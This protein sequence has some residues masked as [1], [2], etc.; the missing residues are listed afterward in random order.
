M[1]DDNNSGAVFWALDNMN[2]RQA[3]NSPNHSHT[4]I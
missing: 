2:E 4:A 1:Y 3:F